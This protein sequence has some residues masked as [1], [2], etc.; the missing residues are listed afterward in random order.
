[1]RERHMEAIDPNFR[2]LPWISRV[3][4]NTYF[5]RPLLPIFNVH[6]FRHILVSIDTSV[7]EISNSDRMEYVNLKT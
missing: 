1:M 2:L 3:A 7:L 4:E 6:V 5:L